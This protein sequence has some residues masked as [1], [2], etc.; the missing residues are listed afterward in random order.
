[1]TVKIKEICSDGLKSGKYKSVVIK[2]DKC[3]D[4]FYI[5][6]SKDKIISFNPSKEIRLTNVTIYERDGVTT[7]MGEN[8]YCYY[9]DMLSKYD[10][11][12]FPKSFVEKNSGANYCRRLLNVKNLLEI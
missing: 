9:T 7:F 4:V 12:I 10:F 3:S 6:S 5:Q 2:K 11:S 8:N 1:M